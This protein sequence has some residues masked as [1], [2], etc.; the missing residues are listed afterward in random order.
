MEIKGQLDET[1]DIYCRF[2]CL[3]NMFRAPLC[4]SSGAR[5]YYT[6]GRC[7]WYLVPWFSSCWYGVE[8]RVMCPKHVEQA[9][10]SGCW[11]SNK[12]CNKYHLLHLVGILFPH[13]LYLFCLPKDK[14]SVFRLVKVSMTPISAKSYLFFYYKRKIEFLNCHWSFVMLV[15]LWLIYRTTDVQAEGS[16]YAGCVTLRDPIV[17]ICNY[18]Q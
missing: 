13:R 3:L 16:F 18:V 2:Y 10:K 1:D 11:A 15:Q 5:E 6:D 12:I 17:C 9:I 14:N 8:L 7:L 4:P